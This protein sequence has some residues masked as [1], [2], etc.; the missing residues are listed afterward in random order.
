LLTVTT[1]TYGKPVNRKTEASWKAVVIEK[2]SPTAEKWTA[3]LPEQHISPLQT[4]RL[5]TASSSQNGRFFLML[6]R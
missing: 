6:W 1:Y 4:A 2:L 5:N 3:S